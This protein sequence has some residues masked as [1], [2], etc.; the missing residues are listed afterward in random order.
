MTSEQRHDA[1]EGTAGGP[2]LSWIVLA[3]LV[4][5]VAAL[6]I[7][8]RGQPPSVGPD[9]RPSIGPTWIA[10]MVPAVPGAA[11]PSPTAPFR[12]QD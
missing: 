1:E 11:T 10:T 8:T 3:A 6:A 9:V 2:W 5:L 12:T 4:L 7:A